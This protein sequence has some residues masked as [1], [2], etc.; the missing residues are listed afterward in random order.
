M[1]FGE[2]PKEWTGAALDTVQSIEQF[3]ILS[4]EIAERIPE[5]LSRYRTFAIWSEGLLRS[6]DEL[7]QSCYAAKKYAAQISHTHA[8][9]LS[10]KERFSY[11]RHV[12]YDKNAYIRVF[13]LL[14]KLGTLINLLLNLQTERIKP[15]FSYFTVIRIMRENHLHTE[16]AKPL[17][18]LKERHQGAL[19][20]LRDRRNLEIH[21]MNAELKDD[22]Q[23][24]L[25]NHHERRSLEDLLSNMSDLDQSW[26]MV[27]GTLSHFFRF[28]CVR[29]RQLS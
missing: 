1:L 22:L 5:Q 26:E 7:E 6:M 24:S 25:A 16:L 21:Q 8:D 11:N 18:E 17:N 19:N 10:A 29:L 15:R 12:Y 13:A 20:R 9:E 2:Q 4:S 14:D 3:I 28:A 27:Q 23:Q